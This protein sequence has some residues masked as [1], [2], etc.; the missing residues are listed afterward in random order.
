MERFDHCGR[1]KRL[2]GKVRAAGLDSFLVTDPAN[3]SYLSGFTGEDAL[4]LIT[5]GEKFF[6]TDSRFVEEAADAVQNCAITLVERS[7]Y[8]TLASIVKKKGLKRIGFESMNLPYA[9]AERLKGIIKATARLVGAK[10]L[11]ESLRAVKD[12]SEVASIKKSVAVAKAVLGMAFK[13]ISPGMSEEFLRRRIES[14]FIERGAKISFDPIIASGAN[15]SKPHARAS[16]AKIENNSFLMVD[17]GCSLGGYNSDITRMAILGHVTARFKKIYA[18]VKRAQEI[19]IEKISPGVRI[20]AIDNAARGY[21]EK[22]GFGKNFGHSLGHGVGLE[23]HEKPSVSRASEGVLQPGMVFTVE[24][25]IY[26]PKFGGVRI[27]DMVLVTDNGCEVL[28]R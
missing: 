14:A 19:A 26:I 16:A 10:D 12:A 8:D 21:I 3:I 15:S 1:M 23:V 17:M 28:T 22:N 20:S 5:P 27:E 13:L 4:I 25:A 9:V 24:P 6:I 2:Q 7:T 11:V 18:I